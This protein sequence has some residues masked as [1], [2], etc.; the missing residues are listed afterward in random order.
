M[1]VWIYLLLALLNGIFG[2]NGFFKIEIDA[3]MFFIFFFIKKLFY[4]FF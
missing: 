3:L 4:F 2:A 1:C